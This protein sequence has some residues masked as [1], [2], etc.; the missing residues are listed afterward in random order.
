MRASQNA[1]LAKKTKTTGESVFFISPQ[2]RS[3]PKENASCYDGTASGRSIYNYF[4]S[5]YDPGTG[6]YGEADPIGLEGGMNLY[7]YV[8]GNPIS[9]IDPLGLFWINSVPCVKALNAFEAALKSCKDEWK[10]CESSEIKQIEF[11]D[12]YG[13][14]FVSTAIFNCAVK[15]N[16]DAYKN[17]IREC[18]SA[19]AS[20]RGPWPIKK[21]PK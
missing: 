14:G 15:K 20:P 3:T 12:N 4:R 5:S 7:A 1:P 8:G 2:T 10:A 18:G 16:P 9:R 19:A 21:L 11:I 17:M 6:R 13:G